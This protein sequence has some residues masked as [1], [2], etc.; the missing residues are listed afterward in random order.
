MLL[1][2]VILRLRRN[3]NPRNKIEHT[4]KQ[5]IKKKKQILPQRE[6][7]QY[8]LFAVRQGK[9][10]LGLYRLRKLLFVLLQHRPRFVGL[11]DIQVA[12]GFVFANSVQVC[13]HGVTGFL[14]N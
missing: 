14:Q 5:R 9:L 11:F 6:V 12:N 7:R 8:L 3:R 4:K 1:P 10:F 2:P 13:I